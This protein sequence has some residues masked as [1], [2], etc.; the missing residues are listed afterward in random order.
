M[1]AIDRKFLLFVEQTCDI[2]SL[3]V[4]PA[5]PDF[6]ASYRRNNFATEIFTFTDPNFC[7]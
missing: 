5:Y 6:R 1:A 4:L 7:F 3:Q 2:D